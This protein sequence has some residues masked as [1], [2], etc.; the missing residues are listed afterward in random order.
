MCGTPVSAASVVS[1]EQISILVADDLG[2][3]REGLV[4][5]CESF[6]AYT[7]VAHCGDGAEACQLIAERQPDLAVLDLNLPRLCTHEILRRVRQLELPTRLVVLSIRN[8]RKTVLE[9]LRSGASAFVLKSGGAAEL[10]EAF[11]QVLRGGVYVS[12]SIELNKVFLPVRRSESQ[13]PLATLSTR[14]HQ[15]FRFLIEGMRAKDIAARLALSPK[16]VDTYRASLMR[17]LDIH[18]VAGLVKF[19]IVRNLTSALS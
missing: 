8:D 11:A 16:T 12:P 13:D 1:T 5:L 15:V 2:L 17:K 10:L 18:D 9:T 6:A 4:A 19:A 14:E 3:V 7:V